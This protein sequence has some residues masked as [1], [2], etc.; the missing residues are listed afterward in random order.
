METG[1]Q[2]KVSSEGLEKT[3]KYQFSEEKKSKVDIIN[4]Y[5]NGTFERQMH[6]F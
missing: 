5:R 3:G 2:F 4:I 6:Q 1:P